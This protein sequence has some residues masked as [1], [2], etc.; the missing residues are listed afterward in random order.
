MSE[1]RKWYWIKD[2]VQ[3]GPADTEEIK[4]YIAFGE[5]K[6][7]TKVWGGSGSWTP[8]Q[9]TELRDLFPKISDTDKQKTPQNTNKQNDITP[10]PVAADEIDNKFVW[11]AVSIPIIGMLI[12]LVLNRQIAWIYLALNSFILL[13]DEYKLKKSGH[14]TPKTWWI[15]LIP[16]YLWIRAKILDQS[17]KHLYAWTAAFLISFP[18]YVWIERTILEDEACPLVTSIIKRMDGDLSCKN[19]DLDDHVTHGFYRGTAILNDGNEINVAVDRIKDG[20][21]VR[22]RDK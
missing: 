19:L 22:I 12:E 3:R 7:E 17:R 9:D 13:A 8:A 21:V 18:L 15:I 2:G 16:G 6:P 10:P 5:I 11:I 1:N 4:G 20:I 14:P